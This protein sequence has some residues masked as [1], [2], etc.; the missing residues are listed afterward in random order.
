MPNSIK[1]YSE[2]LILSYCSII[3][4]KLKKYNIN[5]W[6]LNDGIRS[7]DDPLIPYLYIGE[8]IKIY[9]D[10][11]DYNILDFDFYENQYNTEQ[12][13]ESINNILN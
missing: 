3:N 4:E 11:D 8:C 13:Q 6:F 10:K 1:E 2:S 9:T 12:L 5:F 7:S